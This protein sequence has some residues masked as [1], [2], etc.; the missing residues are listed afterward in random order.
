MCLA[1]SSAGSGFAKVAFISVSSITA[2]AGWP[3]SGGGACGHLCIIISHLL[4][5]LDEWAQSKMNPTQKWV[6]GVLVKTFWCNNSQWY[7]VKSRVLMCFKTS[8]SPLK[9]TMPDD[10]FTLLG[11]LVD[12]ADVT[13]AWFTY[14]P[15]RITLIHGKKR[16]DALI[17][18]GTCCRRRWCH[19]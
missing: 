16:Q 11:L 18:L 1:S 3:L 10:E 5:A 6:L 19:L 15:V 7:I 13:L 14:R 9:E 8:D 4:C 12:H 17:C 2:L